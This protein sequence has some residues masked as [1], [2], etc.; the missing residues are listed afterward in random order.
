MMRLAAE[1]Q[2]MKLGRLS[3]NASVDFCCEG[4]G[5]RWRVPAEKWQGRLPHPHR[6]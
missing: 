4:T 3:L 1:G 2:E 5:G 6:G